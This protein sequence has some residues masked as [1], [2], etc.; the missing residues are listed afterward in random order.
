MR[1]CL[2]I[3]LFGIANPGVQRVG[4]LIGIFFF[5]KSKQK[6]P[7]QIHSKCKFCKQKSPREDSDNTVFLRIACSNAGILRW[8]RYLKQQAL[9]FLL[10]T[11]AFCDVHHFVILDTCAALHCG[12]LRGLFVIHGQDL[13]LGAYMGLRKSSTDCKGQSIS[14]RCIDAH[15]IK[16]TEMFEIVMNRN[17]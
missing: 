13:S 3:C 12:D 2:R 4:R 5:T 8:S 11:S 9:R 10:F 16:W 17:A 1:P 15:R 14:N 7:L 6:F